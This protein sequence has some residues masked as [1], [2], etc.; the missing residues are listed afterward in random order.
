MLRAA[1]DT[2]SPLNRWFTWDDDEAA[3]KHR[4]N[5]ARALIRSVTVRITTTTWEIEA[6][7]FIR[8]PDVGS[9]TQGYVSLGRLRNDEERAREALVGEFA[10]AAGHLQRAQALAVALGMSKEVAELREQIVAAQRIV[11]EG[12]GNG[13]G[14]RN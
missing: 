8:S 5:E 6:P 7:A 10:R 14:P 2:D 3:H 11:E 13:D 12:D 9:R 4:L 1:R